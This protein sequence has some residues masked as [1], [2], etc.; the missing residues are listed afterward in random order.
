M[1]KNDVR[2]LLEILRVAYPKAYSGLSREEAG[3]LVNLYY[4]HFKDSPAD[5]VATALDS[6][7]EA[8]EFPPTIAGLKRFLKQI[9]GGKDYEAMWAEAWSA[10]CGGKRFEQLCPENRAY[11]HSQKAID[12]LGMSSD[13][14]ESVVRGQYMRRIA[15]I[16]ER[17]ETVKAAEKTLGAERLRSLRGGERELTDGKNEQRQ[18]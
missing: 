6:Y 4:R 14:I 5:V 1:D 12:E 10:I 17:R 11:F 16:T 18:R 3:A 2:G 13:T 8:N 9:H 15:E 7:I